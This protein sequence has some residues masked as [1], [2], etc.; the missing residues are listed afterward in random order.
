M[1]LPDVVTR[2]EWLAARKELLAR[3]KEFTRQRD[4]LNA[5]RRRLP[6]TVVQKDYRFDG[7][8]GE[9]S[10]AGLFDGC[11]QLIIQHV[12]F[13]PDWDTICPGCNASLNALP[14]GILAQLRTRDT[15]YAAVSRAPAA[16]IAALKA[17]KGW[18]VDW[19]SSFGSDFNYD[20]QVTIDPSVTPPVYNYE[21]VEVTESTEVGGHSC[22]LTDGDKIFHTYSTYAR[23]SDPT[24]GALRAARPHRARPARG[25]GG[26]QGPGGQTA[27]GRSDVHVLSGREAP[28]ADAARLP[29][30]AGRRAA[31]VTQQAGG[32][33]GDQQHRTRTGALQRRTP[34]RARNSATTADRDHRA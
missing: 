34:T 33:P 20:F 7:P 2:N 1:S 24:I 3:E 19:Y 29:R 14:A 26:A 12:M 32:S 21:P 25:L 18:P 27:P 6:M 13:G 17:A 8:D 4:A 9:V 16:K 23:G 5:E 22:F 10:L 31:A 30:R 15:A 28:S 11:G